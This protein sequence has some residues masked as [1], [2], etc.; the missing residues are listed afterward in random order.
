MIDLLAVSL[1]KK[2]IIDD[3]T[4]Q[5]DNLSISMLAPEISYKIIYIRDYNSILDVL[6]DYYSKLRFFLPLI[7]NR[8]LENI[9]DTIKV[10]I[11]A[12]GIAAS[13]ISELLYHRI[14]L[15]TTIQDVR[16]IISRN[17]LLSPAC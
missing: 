5:L 3:M 16:E 14:E 1:K 15:N 17:R 7:I 4:D 8:F 6:T 2:R 12:R 11:T 10:V 13:D 9:P